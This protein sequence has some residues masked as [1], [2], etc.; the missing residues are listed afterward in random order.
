M[1]RPKKIKIGDVEYRIE[2]PRKVRDGILGEIH[3]ADQLIRVEDNAQWFATLFHEMVHAAFHI[4]GRNKK[5]S[6]RQEEA[7]VLALEELLAP[8]LKLR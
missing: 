7:I 8:L 2:Y 5:L 3:F 6:I 1:R 4:S